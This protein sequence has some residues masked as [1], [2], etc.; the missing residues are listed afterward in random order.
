[1]G[2]KTSAD[3]EEQEAG[4]MP[5]SSFVD[6]EDQPTSDQQEVSES[7]NEPLP[8][9][10][11]SAPKLTAVRITATGHEHAGRP[12][13]IGERVTMNADTARALVNAGRAEYD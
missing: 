8:A 3:S 4:A 5:A 1:M 13:N 2:R 11:G 7:G 10:Y 6:H 9:P 12:C